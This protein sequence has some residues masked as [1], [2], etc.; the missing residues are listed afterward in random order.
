MNG[1]T[2]SSSISAIG[3]ILASRFMRD[4]ACAALDALALKR[5]TKVCRCAR[6]ASCLARVGGLQP[7]L[8]GAHAL[9]VVVAA[10]V[11]VELAFAD[12]Q[13]GVDRVVQ[14]LAVVADDQGGVRIFLQPRLEPQRAFQVEVVGRLVEQQQVGLGEQRRGQRHAHAPAAGE[15]RHRP[16]QVVGGEAEAGEDFGGARRRAVGVDLDQAG[17]DLAHLLRRGGLQRGVERVALGVGG[18]DRCRAG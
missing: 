2:R 10:G 1:A 13:D 11:E 9:E 4:C 6:S 3:A 18:E 12:V 15:L 17:V 5:S 16:R 7:R 14:Q 8:L